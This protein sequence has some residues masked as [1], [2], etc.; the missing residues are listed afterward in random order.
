MKIVGGREV[1]RRKMEPKSMPLMSF[2]WLFE[3]ELGRIATG[4]DVSDDLEDLGLASLT[5]GEAGHTRK[6]KGGGL[7]DVDDYIQ[8][9]DGI[10]V[11]RGEELDLF[12]HDGDSDDLSDDG[13]LNIKD[14]HD[15]TMGGSGELVLA[16]EFRIDSPI[17]EHLRSG[18]G[19]EDVVPRTILDGFDDPREVQSYDSTGLRPSCFKSWRRSPSPSTNNAE[20]SS[21]ATSN[22]ASVATPTSSPVAGIAANT[23]DSELPEEVEEAIVELKIKE[24]PL[25][26]LADLVGGTTISNNVNPVEEVVEEEVVGI[27]IKESPLEKLSKFVG[28]SA[29]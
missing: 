26:K 8:Q 6:R 3:K 12:G 14:S 17:P 23:A 16:T 9:E 13:N 10:I 2:P 29:S 28:G 25:E 22:H 7:V 15:F 20:R 5:L 24:S 1:P 27:D 19:V 4:I 11:H 18:T 21:P